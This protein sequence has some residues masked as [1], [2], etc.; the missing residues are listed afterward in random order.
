LDATYQGHQVFLYRGMNETFKD[1]LEGRIDIKGLD[2]AE[3]TVTPC[4]VGDYFVFPVVKATLK[5]DPAGTASAD[6]PAFKATSLH[7]RTIKDDSGSQWI[8]ARDDPQR[9]S[10]RQSADSG[11]REGY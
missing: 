6:T 1:S 4:G 9:L 7:L 8:C 10:H 11:E 2:A 3:V 5:Q